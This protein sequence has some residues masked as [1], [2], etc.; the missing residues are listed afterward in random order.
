M[1]NHQLSASHASTWHAAAAVLSAWLITC[2]AQLH[3][4]PAGSKLLCRPEPAQHYCSQLASPLQPS[5]WAYTW[6]WCSR[7]ADQCH[8]HCQSPCPCID[9]YKAHNHLMCCHY[10]RAVGAVL[11]AGYLYSNGRAVPCPADTYQPLHYEM[12]ITNSSASACLPCP[13]GSTTNGETAARTC[14]CEWQCGA[15]KCLQRAARHMAQ[16]TA[17]LAAW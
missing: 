16:H 1:L 10:L 17:Q 4:Q 6:C 2:L 5:M 7:Q 14:R 12:L 11:A 9:A 8:M 15:S 13:V 3:V